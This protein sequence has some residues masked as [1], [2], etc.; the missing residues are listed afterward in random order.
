MVTTVTGIELVVLFRSNYGQFGWRKERRHSG[1]R[2]G[3]MMH[4]QFNLWKAAIGVV[5]YVIVCIVI[6]CFSPPDYAA[7]APP[8]G[9]A[10]SASLSVAH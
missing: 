9:D 7:P 6:L 4:G 10:S 8:R 2:I 5:I 1:Y 3:A